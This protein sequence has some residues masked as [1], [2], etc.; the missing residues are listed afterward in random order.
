MEENDFEVFL[1]YDI[2]L[3]CSFLCK[4]SNPFRENSSVVFIG[5][6]PWLHEQNFLSSIKEA[7]YD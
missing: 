7:R 5:R 6:S 2:H 3:S 4:I 1:H